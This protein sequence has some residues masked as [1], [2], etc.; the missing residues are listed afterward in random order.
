MNW[1]GQR[2]SLEHLI[3]LATNPARQASLQADHDAKR[4][5]RI[6]SAL[7]TRPIFLPLQ[8]SMTAAAQTAP[9]RDLTP[10]LA[11]DV[12]I[13]GFK[14]DTPSRQIS[15]RRTE[16]DR[17]LVRIG[18]DLNL[19]LTGSDV[20]GGTAGISPGQNGTFYLP[21]PLVVP[22][23]TRVTVEMYKQDATADPEVANL[24][25][26]GVRVLNPAYAD[27]LLDD[28]EKAL[29]DHCIRLAP[30]S[31]TLFL[32]QSVA[33]DV[34]GVGGVAEN[35]LGPRVEV[36]LLIRGMRTTLANSLIE[37]NINGEPSWTP[38]PTPIWAVATEDDQRNDAYQWF[39]K[40]IYLKS[41]NQIEIV[42]VTNGGVDNLTFDN[43]T[44]NTITWVC[45]TV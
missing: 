44:G 17:S 18:D 20:A 11:Y 6:Q 10:S 5:S 21:S 8:F 45:E 2:Q 28:A 36:P 15:I 35:L 24:V 22:K 43:Q 40:P 3:S 13:T 7:S 42:R 30:T 16:N 31:T 39:S 12:I 23:G 37:L 1:N 25:L 34:A 33:F 32:K 4:R 29:I 19:F 14:T 38:R 27:V 9:Y 41:D 26:V